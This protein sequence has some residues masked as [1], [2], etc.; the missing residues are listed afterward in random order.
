MGR[1]PA[2][3]R[4]KPKSTGGT[5]WRD[6]LPPVRSVRLPIRRS[7]RRVGGAAAAG[8]VPRP[9]PGPPGMP[10]VMVSPL[11]GRSRTGCQRGGLRARW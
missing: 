3:P 1:Q 6:P 7:T 4:A 10:G 5:T 8:G 2:E 9:V 11:G